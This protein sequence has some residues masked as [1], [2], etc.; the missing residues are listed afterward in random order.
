MNNTRDLERAV[1]SLDAWMY[2]DSRIAI[3]VLGSQRITDLVKDALRK[4][5]EVS[6]RFPTDKECELLVTGGD[7]GEI[8]EDLIKLF[9]RTHAYLGTFF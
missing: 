6:R 3:R 4:D 9:P 5:F 7:E 1:D 2:C 8:P